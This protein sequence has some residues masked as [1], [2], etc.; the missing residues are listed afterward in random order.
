MKS[1]QMSKKCWIYRSTAPRSRRSPPSCVL[2]STGRCAACTLGD[3]LDDPSCLIKSNL[4]WVKKLHRDLLSRTSVGTPT[5]SLG[6]PFA[7]RAKLKLPSSSRTRLHT[8]MP[9]SATSA[10]TCATRLSKKV[11]R[12][13]PLKAC[14]RWIWNPPAPC[15][16]RPPWPMALLIGLGSVGPGGLLEADKRRLKEP[17]S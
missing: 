5:V 3:G 16:A 15:A 8:R 9:I 12:R 13:Q 6:A 1:S 17:G 11:Q 4:P 2:E 14:G 10:L 7:V